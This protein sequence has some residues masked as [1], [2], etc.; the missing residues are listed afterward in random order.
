M[1]EMVAEIGTENEVYKNQL[2]IE[3]LM[4]K[5]LIMMGKR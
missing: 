1:E 4:K 3:S 2:L 5:E